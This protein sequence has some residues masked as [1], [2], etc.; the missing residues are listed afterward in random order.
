MID[1]TVIEED[2]LT[3]LI[4]E[5]GAEDINIEDPHAYQVITAPAEFDAVRSYLEEKEV[6]MLSAEL[7]WNPQNR[8]EIDDSKKAEQVIKLIDFLEDDDD[9]KSVHSNF[10]ISENV[11]AELG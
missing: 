11:M 7:I 8:I 3:E 6:V 10:D 5:A 1:K 9:V 2:P 4:L